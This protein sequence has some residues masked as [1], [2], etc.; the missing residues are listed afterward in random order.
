VWLNNAR[1]ANAAAQEI[2]PGA[3]GD[4]LMRPVEAGRGRRSSAPPLNA[5]LCA[6]FGFYRT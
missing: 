6:S 4:R 3:A 2:A 5:Q 1:A